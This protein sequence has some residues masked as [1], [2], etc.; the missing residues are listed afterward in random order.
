MNKNPAKSIIEYARNKVEKYNG[1]HPEISEDVKQWIHLDEWD[2]LIWDYEYSRH[3]F[4]YPVVNGE[5]N[6]SDEFKLIEKKISFIK[7]INTRYLK[8]II[9]FVI[10]SVVFSSRGLEYG[11]AISFPLTLLYFGLEEGCGHSPGEGGMS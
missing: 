4:L 2:L 8:Y 10:V 1:D 6:L 3:A 7:R 9:V 11:I 5:T